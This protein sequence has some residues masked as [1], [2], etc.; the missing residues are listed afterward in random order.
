MSSITTSYLRFTP[1]KRRDALVVNDFSFSEFK[2]FNSGSPVS[3]VGTTVTSVGWNGEPLSYLVDGNDNTKIHSYSHTNPSQSPFVFAFSSPKTI[4]SYKFTY[5]NTMVEHPAYGRTPIRWTLEA[6]N[7]GSTW[8]MIDDRSG[9]DQT[10]A[11]PAESWGEFP[12]DTDLYTVEEVP[13]VIA[14]ATGNSSVPVIVNLD[15]LVDASG[16]INVF[17]ATAPVVTNVIVAQTTLPVNTLYDA[18][19]VTNSNVLNSLFEFWEPSSALGTRSATKC[20]TGTRD[21]TKMTG[22]LVKKMQMVLEGSFDCSAASPF[23]DPKYNGNSNY[24]T[25]PDFG[26]LAL[27]AYAHYLFGH[28]AATS[29]ITNDK[30]FMEGI[31][32]QTVTDGSGNAIYKYKTESVAGNANG[33]E[34]IS[35]TIG[36][37]SDADIARLIVGA[38]VNKNDAA[39]LAIVEQVLGQDA[40]RTMDQDNNQ[41]SPDVRQP[42]KFIQGD[43]IYLN[44]RLK[45]PVVSVGGGQQVSSGTLEGKYPSDP[46]TETNYTLKV[47]LEN[48]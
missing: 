38:L 34:W 16:N 28:V 17:G 10:V 41:L 26:R 31:L 46:H 9:A 3:V 48:K 35:G 1:L 23:S 21:Y 33:S 14:G 18:S 37:A 36:T 8:T 13:S 47:T 45:Q 32:S 5:L 19:G 4:D 20:T 6:S 29:A 30:A 44:I 7:N 27:S 15:V 40:S 42:L 22:S 25:Q 39:I 11:A 2:I 12:T 24:T 43:V